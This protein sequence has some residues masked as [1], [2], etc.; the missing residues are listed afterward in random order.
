MIKFWSFII[1][2]LFVSVV[3]AEYRLVW[4]DEFETLNV[5]VWTHEVGTGDNGWGNFEQETYSDSPTNSFVDNYVLNICALRIPNPFDRVQYT[6]ARIK[7]QG[8]ISVLYGKIEARMKLPKR[9]KGVWPAFW[10]LGE[11]IESKGWPYCGEIDIMEWKGSEP[12]S[13]ISTSHWNGNPYNY[14]HCNYGS[15]LNLEFPLDEDFYTFG[16]EWTPIKLEY[17]L[18]DNANQKF[19]INV[20]DI[21]NAN[22]ANGL[23]CFHKPAFILLNLAMGGQFDGDVATDLGDRTFQIDWVRVYQDNDTYPSSLLINNTQS[24][25]D[26]IIE[27]NDI[28]RVYRN[29]NG[30]VIDSKECGYIEVF[31]Y[32]GKLVL[33]KAI[34]AGRTTI[35]HV[36]VVSVVR[37]R[38]QDF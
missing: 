24:G 1:L 21:S 35:N 32:D 27:S 34:S 20:I 17:Y 30:I 26:N 23:S 6:S 18:L 31:S 38:K 2:S 33:S 4:Q 28:V 14:E 37:F 19:I 29:K 8:N 15:T 9:G 13:V 36:P 12:N 3:N 10:M 16:V 22:D 5:E 7:T 25:I 11:S